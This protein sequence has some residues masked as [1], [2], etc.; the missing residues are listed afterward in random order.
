VARS[1]SRLMKSE[2]LMPS[3]AARA[4]K[5]LCTR[6]ETLLPG[7]SWTFPYPAAIPISPL[8]VAS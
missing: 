3:S 8:Q 4:F 2:R 5:V 1:N 7:S 6:S